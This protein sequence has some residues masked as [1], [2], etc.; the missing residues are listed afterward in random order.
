MGVP[1]AGAWGDGGANTFETRLRGDA[2]LSPECSVIV[3]FGRGAVDRPDGSIRSGT[4][5]LSEAQEHPAARARPGR[6]VCTSKA[7]RRLVQRF[8][9]YVR[10]SRVIQG[11]IEAGQVCVDKTMQLI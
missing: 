4:E 11:F 1:A 10:N 8:G 6:L 9:G 7:P 2:M 3:P 5:V